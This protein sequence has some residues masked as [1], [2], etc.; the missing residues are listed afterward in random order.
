MSTP[1][2]AQIGICDLCGGSIPRR[3]WY[4]SHGKPRRYCSVDCRNTANSRAGNPVRTA[5]L[6]R[7]VADGRWRNPMRIRP[8]TGAEQAARARNG[9]LREVAENRWR[10][11]GLTPEARAINSQPEKH[12]GAL[13]H[14]IEK[15]GRGLHVGDL[16]PEE[17]SAYRAY[18][19]A[20]S[21]A[22]RQRW[23]PEQRS[24]WRARWRAAWHRRHPRGDTA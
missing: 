19:R 16:T 17:A 14:A 1:K 6:R 5:K 15:L 20:Q 22:W 11:P 13:A 3:D 8:P 7:A 21:A 9:R 23:T 18:R 24:S 10:N 2:T 4:T 12:T